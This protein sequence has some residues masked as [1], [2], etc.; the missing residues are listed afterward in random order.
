K[1]RGANRLVESAGRLPIPAPRQIR[2]SGCPASG[3]SAAVARGYASPLPSEV[4]VIWSP[5]STQWAWFPTTT[6]WLPARHGAHCKPGPLNFSLRHEVARL[7]VWRV[8]RTRP[9]VLSAVSYAEVREGNDSYRALGHGT[10]SHP[11]GTGTVRGRC[12]CQHQAETGLD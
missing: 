12:L 1:G 5:I 4:S 11:T 8:V 7:I 10:H 3:S 9:A 2:T 6:P